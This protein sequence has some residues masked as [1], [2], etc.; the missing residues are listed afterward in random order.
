MFPLY[1]LL[2]ILSPLSGTIETMKLATAPDQPH[3]P[4][5]IIVAPDQPRSPDL[6]IVVPDIPTDLRATAV[7]N[8]VELTWS[9][10]S[11]N[12]TDNDITGFEYEVIDGLWL[13]MEGANG[14]STRYLVTDLNY[15]TTYNFR[16]RAV[17]D[18]QKG[19][20]SN[21]A[22]VTIVEQPEAPSQ[23]K[24]LL[25]SAPQ[26]YESVPYFRW[27]YVDPFSYEFRIRDEHGAAFVD[28]TEITKQL[29]S[30]I[31]KGSTTLLAEHLLLPGKE[32]T[33]ELRAFDANVKGKI[34]EVNITPPY[35]EP[36]SPLPVRSKIVTGG[37]QI[38]WNDYTHGSAPYTFEYRIK[39]L[40]KSYGA[41]TEIIDP[42]PGATTPWV[43]DF[44]SLTY[45]TVLKDL[46]PSTAY[47]IQV[48]TSFGDLS[49][50]GI[51]TTI[52]TPATF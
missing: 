42:T 51:V 32:Y 48:R 8:S 3:S 6:G 47:T 19:F 23:F 5:I 38:S 17:T 49:S 7:G 22:P 9:S 45:T 46:K 44:P 31:N 24:V 12:T 21:V 35:R 18:T 27:K 1:A 14:F 52:T 25:G 13:P 50:P 30:P 37:V 39:E 43:P 33:F 2:S 40:G 20:P 29:M 26:S 15:G 36:L 28:W 4:E 10:P 11:S 41:W 34:S 16:I